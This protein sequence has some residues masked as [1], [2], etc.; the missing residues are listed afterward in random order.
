MQG[1]DSDIEEDAEML[2]LEEE[3]PAAKTG[4]DLR[5]RRSKVTSDE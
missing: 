2:L 5:S 1:I 4:R 3:V